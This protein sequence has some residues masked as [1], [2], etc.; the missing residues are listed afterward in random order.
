MHHIDNKN[1]VPISTYYVFNIQITMASF[2]LPTV[3]IFLYVCIYA[4]A[5]MQLKDGDIEKE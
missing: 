2:V 5:V 3:F 4:Y 1:S